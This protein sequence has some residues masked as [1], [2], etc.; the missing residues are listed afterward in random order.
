MPDVTRNKRGEW[1]IA[2]VVDRSEYGTTHTMRKLYRIPVSRKATRGEA[3]RAA[4]L[5]M[6][7][8]I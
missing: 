2:A 3:E 7:K 6:P 5:L 4:L 1:C 8:G